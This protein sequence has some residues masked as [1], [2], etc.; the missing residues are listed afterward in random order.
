MAEL[1]L[2][3]EMWLQKCQFCTDGP[4]DHLQ[5]RCHVFWG[6]DK[7][8]KSKFS[9]HGMALHSKCSCN[10]A[11]AIVA[12]DFCTVVNTCLSLLTY[13]NGANGLTMFFLE[14]GMMVIPWRSLKYM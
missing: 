13:L 1:C 11:N 14:T 2:Y 12:R 5:K 6:N 7:T 9:S 10:N 8:V 4:T 3:K